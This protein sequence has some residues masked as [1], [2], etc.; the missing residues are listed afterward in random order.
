MN[1]FLLHGFLGRPSDWEAV[2]ASLPPVTNLRIYTPDYF[3]DEELT[4]VHSFDKWAENFNDWAHDETKGAGKNILV[5]YSLGGRLALQALAQNPTQW[6]RALLI[7]TNPGFNDNCKHF[8]P[9]SEQRKQRWL[10]DSYWAEE[11]L[12]APWDMVMRNWNAQPVFGGGSEPVRMEKDY[13]RENLS[14]ALTR[15]SLAEQQNMRNLLSAL[16]QKVLW[17]VGEKDEKFVSMSQAL[18][19]ETGLEIEIAQDSSHRVLFDRPREIA[20]LI[21]NIL[22]QLK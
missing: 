9:S 11:F 1:L 16:K 6:Y 3:K 21:K 22:S 7:S 2:K 15:W 19:H 10:S 17:L 13:N 12:K 20:D 5:G 14:L 8:D 4:S 18:E